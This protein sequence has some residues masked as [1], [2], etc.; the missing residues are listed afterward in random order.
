MGFFDFLTGRKRGSESRDT[1][2]SSAG[3]YIPGTDNDSD[4]S[5]GGSGDSGGGDG[6]SG[7]GGA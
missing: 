1:S 6:G 5:D 3:T 7:D 4:G 2:N